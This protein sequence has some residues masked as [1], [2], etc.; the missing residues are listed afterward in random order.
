M[1]DIIE[2]MRRIVTINE[3]V[4]LRNKFS[5]SEKVILTT[6]VFDGLHIE[7]ERFLKKAKA[8]G[9]ILIVGIES[10]KRVRE[11]KGKER[12]LN[13]QKKRAAAIALLDWVD[14][15]FIMPTNLGTRRG[16]EQLIKNLKPDVYAI[17]ANTPFKAEKDRIMK[18][19]GGK[20]K[21][22]HPYNPEIST[23]KMLGAH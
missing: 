18:K 15:A 13:S 14:Y 19:F 4:V 20:L 2:V 17:S 16:R 12:P 9:N 5:S 3:I 1:G 6:G 11:L 21:V 7:H 23:T 8:C 10:D 22:V